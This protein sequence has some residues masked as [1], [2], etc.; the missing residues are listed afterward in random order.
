VALGGEPLRRHE[1]YAVIFLNPEPH[2]GQIPGLL[3]H[4]SEFLE[5][6]FDVGYVAPIRDTDTPIPIRRYVDTAF[7]KNKDT[8][9]RQVH[10]MLYNNYY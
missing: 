1:E 7:S 4:V 10:I 8:P 2:Q 3:Q 6:H 5:H 9:I